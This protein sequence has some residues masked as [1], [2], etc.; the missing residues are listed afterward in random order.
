MQM[1]IFK[2]K[3]VILMSNISTP[4]GRFPRISPS[5]ENRS[6]GKQNSKVRVV[7]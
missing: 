7:S 4:A 2:L 6:I 3:I 5:A 1:V